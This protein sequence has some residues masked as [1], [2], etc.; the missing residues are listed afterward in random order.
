MPIQDVNMTAQLRAAKGK[1]PKAASSA[2]VARLLEGF[3]HEGL[4]SIPIRLRCK[5]PEITC[6]YLVYSGLD[7]YYVGQTVNLKR[8]WESHHTSE[9]LSIVQD[10][11]EQQDVRIGWIGLDRQ[12]LTLIE[13]ALIGLL[14][15]ILNVSQNERYSTSNYEH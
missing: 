3:N 10:S 6:V 8:R 11:T 4:H 13:K 1:Q 15:P 7:V 5:L 2:D 9:K 12:L 14:L